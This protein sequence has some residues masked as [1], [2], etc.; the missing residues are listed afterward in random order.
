MRS[1]LAKGLILYV[2]VPYF[3]MVLGIALLGMSAL[4]ACTVAIGKTLSWLKTALRKIKPSQPPASG[5]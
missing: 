5:T 4:Y 3:K 2:L 1:T